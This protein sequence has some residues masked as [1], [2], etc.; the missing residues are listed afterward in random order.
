MLPEHR[1]LFSLHEGRPGW[2]PGGFLGFH[3]AAWIAKWTSIVAIATRK[4]AR[5]EVCIDAS[6]TFAGG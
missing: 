6:M 2:F 4:I 1:L 3:E 5:L